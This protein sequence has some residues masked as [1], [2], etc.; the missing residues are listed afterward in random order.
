MA[1][2]FGWRDE[3]HIIG[4]RKGRIQVN[5]WCLMVSFTRKMIDSFKR[6]CKID[7]PQL[8]HFLGCLES[9][10]TSRWEINVMAHSQFH[11]I[12][13]NVGCFKIEWRCFMN[14]S[15][16]LATF[17]HR[18]VLLTF[19]FFVFLLFD[20]QLVKTSCGIEK[21]YQYLAWKLKA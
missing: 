4:R 10:S 14:V 21:F 8:I 15:S 3:Y 17:T 1:Y 19:P 11:M 7:V 9:V 5:E 18:C 2:I 16:F 12:C 6:F 13:S 20:D